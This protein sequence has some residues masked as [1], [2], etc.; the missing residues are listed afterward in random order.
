MNSNRVSELDRRRFLQAAAAAGVSA[1]LAGSAAWA[2]SKDPLKIGVTMPLTGSQAGYGNDFIIGMRQ[3]LKD[4]NDAGGINGRPL[5]LVVIDTQA[6]P[7]ARHQRREQ[8]HQRRQGPDLPHGLERGRE[9]PGADR[10]SRKSAGLS[11][12]APMRPTSRIS[13]S[14]STRRFRS[15]RSIS[16]ALAKYTYETLGKRRPRCSTSTTRPA[17]TQRS[18]TRTRSRRR[19]ARS[20]SSRPMTPR[21]PNS[22]ACC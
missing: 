12:P 4:V 15:P 8:A 14:T 13:A 7:A 18:S 22:P 17:S 20:S 10:Q 11:V 19:A 6:E 5:E 9:G 1:P 3:A 2:Q 16:R 21:R